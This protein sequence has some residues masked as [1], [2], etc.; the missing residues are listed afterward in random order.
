[1]N[2]ISKDRHSFGPKTGSRHA[3]CLII[4]GAIILLLLAAVFLGPWK[5]VLEDRVKAVLAEKGFKDVQLSVAAITP[6]QLLLSDVSLRGA[7]PITLKNLAL[8]FTID[9][10]KSG[11]FDS[12]ALT[13]LALSLPP[14]EEKTKTEA[15]PALAI[16]VKADDLKTL[17][18]EKI[19]ISDSHFDV[20][21]TGLNLHIPFSLNFDKAKKNIGLLA[22]NLTFKAGGI[23]ADAGTSNV[24]LD[25]KE[26]EQRWEGAWEIKDIVTAGFDPPLPSF[27]GKGHVRA[28]ASGVQAGGTF[29]SK[30][31]A[32][33][34]NF[35]ITYPTDKPENA[36]LSI[37]SAS[38]PW[39][40]GKISTGGIT[41]P[42]S[43][44]KKDMSLTLKVEK[45]SLDALMQLL[46]GKKASATGLVS[47]N[48]PITIKKDGSLV[49][50]NGTLQAE[51]P[52]II[53]LSE[54]A[55]PGENEQLQLVRQILKKLNYNVLSVSLENDK[56]GKLAIRMALEGMNPDFQEGHPVKLNVQL[57]GDVLGFLQQN[58]MLLFDPKKILQ[59]SGGDK[60]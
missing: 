39:H 40:E 34:A 5:A 6:T 14:A 35:T 53:S 43:G 11:R 42:L 49:I 55:I 58:V 12:V 23:S 52:G 32:T 1:M 54:D 4:I 13:G 51:A 31:G 8:N 2:D 60:K 16:P 29:T 48:V 25:L 19:S 9:E 7:M 47:G 41:M 50:H 10:L 33:R 30:D 17:P 59:D 38:M 37:L 20:T 21:Q 24:S 56:D 44:V 26:Q 28:D 36:M 3:G 45:V 27:Y 18:F 15:A 22:P 46:T 57:G